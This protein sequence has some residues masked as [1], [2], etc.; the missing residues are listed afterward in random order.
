MELGS[1]DNGETLD[2]AA[3]SP[4]HHL[5][6]D[7]VG[8]PGPDA[9]GGYFF[10]CPAS[11]VHYVLSSPPYSFSSDAAPARATVD[12]G[13]SAGPFEFDGTIGGG[14]MTSADELFLDGQ[15]RPLRLSSHLLRP[16]R[17][18]PLLDGDEEE[19]EMT[20]EEEEED[21]RGRGM[22]MRSRS[23]HRRTR[24]MSPLRSPRFQWQEEEKMEKRE[25]AKRLEIIDKDSNKPAAATT[26]ESAS[27]SRSSSTSSTSSGGRSSK[28]WIFLKDFLLHRS[29]SEGSER[30]SGG[31]KDRFWR[32][33]SFSPSAKS[34]PSLPS[35]ASSPQAS[36][37]SSPAAEQT[38]TRTSKR[39]TN[40]VATRRR[41]TRAAAAASA[42]ERHYTASRAQAE[43]MRRRTFLPYRQGLLS[44]LGFTSRG[45]TAFNILTKALNP[46]ASK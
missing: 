6:G 15:I 27:S 24:S 21:G 8:S 2:C 14:A 31:E 40:G 9:P 11:P 16:Q 10:S 29:K 5:I 1:F 45:Y 42:H 28:R 7:A 46:V 41:P 4:A 22:R 19:G 20:E 34:K 26:P 43:E 23:L 35:S 32:S 39:L 17:L 37:T 36:A 38:K 12:D 33:I 44:C 18:A 3:F 30:D 25:E 13:W